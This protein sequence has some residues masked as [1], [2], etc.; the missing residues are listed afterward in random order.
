MEKLSRINV[1]HPTHLV[2]ASSA[3]YSQ[4]STFGSAPEMRD[5]EKLSSLPG[6]IITNL[7]TLLHWFLLTPWHPH[8]LTLLDIVA[9]LHGNL[10]TVGHLLLV[11]I[12]LGREELLVQGGDPDGPRDGC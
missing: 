11:A 7:P 8:S 9:R 5:D 10:S 3:P 4:S 6:L 1:F 2:P 12:V